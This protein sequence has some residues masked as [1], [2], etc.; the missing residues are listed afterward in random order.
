MENT[1]AASLSADMDRKLRAASRTATPIILS[2]QQEAPETL[3]KV[4]D[5]D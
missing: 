5:N 2:L 3:P 1:I 4:S